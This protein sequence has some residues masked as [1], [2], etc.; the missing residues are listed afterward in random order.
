MFSNSNMT[1]HKFWKA[2]Q[3]VTLGLFHF[4]DPSNSYTHT[5]YNHSQ[6][7]YQAWL[8]GLLFQGEFV[9]LVNSHVRLRQQDP[10]RALHGKHAGSQVHPSGSKMSLRPSKHVLACGWHFLDSQLVQTVLIENQELAGN[11]INYI[12]YKGSQL[13]T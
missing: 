11:I 9:N 13:Y 3:I 4:I 7:Y 5:L 2:G 12:E 1:D 10:W 6:W 8:I